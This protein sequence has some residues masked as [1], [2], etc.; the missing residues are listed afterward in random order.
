MAEQTHKV[1]VAKSADPEFEFTYDSGSWLAKCSCGW[2]EQ[3]T[4]EERA[5]TSADAHEANPDGE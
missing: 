3:R 5:Q 1:K 4:T 2:S